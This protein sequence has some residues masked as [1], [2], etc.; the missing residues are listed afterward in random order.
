MPAPIG[1]E[2]FAPPTS[3]GEL[4]RAWTEWQARVRAQAQ[5]LDGPIS[6]ARSEGGSF[7]ANVG[8]ILA[9]VNRLAPA[10][11]ASRPS[12]ARGEAGRAA[13]NVPGA[14]AALRNA[15]QQAGDPRAP[16]VGG[17][18]GGAEGAIRNQTDPIESGG[19]RIEGSAGAA[20]DIER[21]I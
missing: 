4:V 13:A 7:G 12:H 21:R 2:L 6:R 11:D 14:D 17:S 10:V 5:Q 18:T 1:G 16:Q 20:E 9:A 15:E 8:N 19:R 3:S